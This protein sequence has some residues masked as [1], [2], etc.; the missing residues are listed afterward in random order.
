LVIGNSR[1]PASLAGFVGELGVRATADTVE[2]VAHRADLVVLAL[3]L[4]AYRS[5]PVKQ[6]DGKVVIDAMNYYPRYTG[7]IDEIEGRGMFSSLLV[8]EHLAEAKVVKGFNNIDFVR[9]VRSSNPNGDPQRSAL[10]IAGDDAEAKIRVA[11][12]MDMVGF[13]S[14]DLGGLVEG[15]RFQPGTPLYVTPYS[16]DLENPSDDPATRFME[17]ETVPVSREDARRLAAQATHG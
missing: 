5:L 4:A 17:A 8:Q 14:I 9:L 11:E 15:W 7:T 2:G 16:R 3:P 10:P 1:G 6:F 12:F 13:D